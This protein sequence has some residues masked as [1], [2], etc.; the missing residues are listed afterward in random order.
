[1]TAM[2]HLRGLFARAFGVL[3]GLVLM[4]QVAV[5]HFPV[6]LP[7]APGTMRLVICGHGGL[8]TITINLADG[9][10]ETDSGTGESKCP[11]CIMSVADLLPGISAPIASAD[12]RRA[13]CGPTDALRI[14]TH[15]PDPA[16]PIR[17][18]P[19]QL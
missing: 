4:A 5:S 13:D 18:P 19:R 14:A 15:S 17:A 6:D 12:Y 16:A 8:E 3:F 2:L 1:M 7:L 11:F 9:T 10:V